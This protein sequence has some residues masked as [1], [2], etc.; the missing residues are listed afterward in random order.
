MPSLL[1]MLLLLLLLMLLLLLLSSLL[2]DSYSWYGHLLRKLG[3]LVDGSQLATAHLTSDAVL[4][5]VPGV[6]IR[7]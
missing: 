7:R 2:S 6:A 1:L 4:P 5:L 3:V